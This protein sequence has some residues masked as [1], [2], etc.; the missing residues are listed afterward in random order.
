MTLLAPSI[1]RNVVRWALPR[2]LMYVGAAVCS[3]VIFA[4]GVIVYSMFVPAPHQAAILKLVPV[5]PHIESAPTAAPPA[6]IASE[7]P[8]NLI[9]TPAF[10]SNN[11]L[12][13]D[14][15]QV[16]IGRS[17]YA[18]AVVVELNGTIKG[19]LY[20]PAGEVSVT[21]LKSENKVLPSRAHVIYSLHDI[22]SAIRIA[23]SKQVLDSNAPLV[24][25]S[26]FSDSS[27]VLVP[28]TAK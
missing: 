10:D 25:P 21:Y 23:A 12:I 11:K 19:L 17:G 18:G 5:A 13:G 15:T 24:M 22:E 8:K 2:L 26:S 3:A 14:I 9:G 27:T 28:P 7:S 4:A 16:S 20:V 1:P 6:L